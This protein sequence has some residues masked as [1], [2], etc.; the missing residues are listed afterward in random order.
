MTTSMSTERLMH[1][2]EHAASS[3]EQNARARRIMLT[4]AANH[5]T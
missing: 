1:G 3:D 2:C 5:L 4:M